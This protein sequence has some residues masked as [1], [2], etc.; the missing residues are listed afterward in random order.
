MAQAVKHGEYKIDGNVIMS[1]WDEWFVMV[2]QTSAGSAGYVLNEKDGSA[3]LISS[4]NPLEEW[5]IPNELPKHIQA[6]ARL[7]FKRLYRKLKADAERN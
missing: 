5:N 4:A 7:C 2:S 3:H 6:R 1:K